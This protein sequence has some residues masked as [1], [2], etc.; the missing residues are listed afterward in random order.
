MYVFRCV[1]YKTFIFVLSYKKL[2]YIMLI[3]YTKRVCINNFLRYYFHHQLTVGISNPF[4]RRTASL[5]FP[6]PYCRFDDSYFG[7]LVVSKLCMRQIYDIVG[8]EQANSFDNI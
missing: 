6:S 8:S 7:T 2:D 3:S 4:L 1:D 5:R